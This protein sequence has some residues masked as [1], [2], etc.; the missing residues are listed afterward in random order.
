MAEC[1]QNAPRN[2]Q[3]RKKKEEKKKKQTRTAG[4]E[5]RRAA[6]R[7]SSSSSPS[8]LGVVF[9]VSRVGVAAAAG[10]QM[11]MIMLIL[12]AAESALAALLNSHI[13]RVSVG[14]QR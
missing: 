4:G 11:P 3:Q 1:V 14:K 2:Q 5:S 7:T 8:Q 12:T 10:L 9:S 13:L 6:A